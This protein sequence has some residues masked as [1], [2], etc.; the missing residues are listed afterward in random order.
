MDKV[1]K[2][3]NDKLDEYDNL[4]EHDNLDNYEITVLT[5]VRKTRIYLHIIYKKQIKYDKF[6]SNI[7]EEIKSISNKYRMFITNEIF[8]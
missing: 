3:I 8:M 1:I 2:M 7:I 6:I 5:P 4:D